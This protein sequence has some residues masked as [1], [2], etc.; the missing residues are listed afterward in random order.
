MY[1]LFIKVIEQKYKND[2]HFQNANGE[3]PEN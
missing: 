3:L 2:P 1:F